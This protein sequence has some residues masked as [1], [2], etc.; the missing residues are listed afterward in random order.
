MPEGHFLVDFYSVFFS[1]CRGDFVKFKVYDIL[2]A[3]EFVFMATC[4][5]VHRFLCYLYD[6]I[7]N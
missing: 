3:Y 5:D 2:F 1:R 6:K 7:S 4:I